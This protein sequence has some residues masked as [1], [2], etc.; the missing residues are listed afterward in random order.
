M[1]T[2]RSLPAF[3]YA[4]WSEPNAETQT[5]RFGRVILTDQKLAEYVIWYQG[6]SPA[7]AAVW[8][9]FLAKCEPNEQ[10]SERI[11]AFRF[12]S[13]PPLDPNEPDEQPPSLADTARE[14]ILKGLEADR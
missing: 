3:S 7:E 11:E 1:A 5:E 9:A 14:L 6:L 8:D 10:L 13:D 2:D 4:A 12:P